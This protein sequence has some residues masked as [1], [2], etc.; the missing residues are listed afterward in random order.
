MY[1]ISRCRHYTMHMVRILFRNPRRFSS[2]SI[3]SSTAQCGFCCITMSGQDD[4]VI[5]KIHEIFWKHCLLPISF[6]LFIV[7]QDIPLFILPVIPPK[8]YSHTIAIHYFYKCFHHHYIKASSAL[9]TKCA[10]TLKKKYEVCMIIYIRVG[11]GELFWMELLDLEEKKWK[12]EI[13][14]VT[15]FFTCT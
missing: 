2:R 11:L 1:I 5:Y 9:I 3:V 12:F 7:I 6:F 13:S 10:N 8:S 15:P 4:I 14:C